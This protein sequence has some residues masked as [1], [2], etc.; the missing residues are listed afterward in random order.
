MRIATWNV[1]SLGVCGILENMKLE[2]ERYKIDVL[3]ISEIKWTGLGDF[4]LEII[5]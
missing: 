1:R 2:M 5:E 4:G 3:G